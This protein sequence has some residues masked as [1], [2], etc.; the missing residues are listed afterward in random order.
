MKLTTMLTFVFIIL[1]L[2]GKLTLGW[3]WVLSPY[4]I[5]YLLLLICKKLIN[6]ERGNK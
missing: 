5:S 2:T 6:K 4:W 3:I 1:K